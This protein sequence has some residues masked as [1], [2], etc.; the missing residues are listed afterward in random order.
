MIIDL[1]AGAPVRPVITF[2]IGDT[3]YR[4]TGTDIDI[5]GKLKLFFSWSILNPYSE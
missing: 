5:T 3:E 4:Y 1:G 2:K